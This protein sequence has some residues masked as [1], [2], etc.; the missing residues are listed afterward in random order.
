[1]GKYA[2]TALFSAVVT[3]VAVS[4]FWIWFYN[5]VLQG[6]P[7]VERSGNVVAVV[8]PRAPP[9][10]VA[11]QV[12]VG[13]SGLALP[14]MGVKSDQLTD[15]FTQARAN[16][17]LHDAIDIMAPEGT[18]VIAAADGTIEK[19]FF[20]HGGGGITIYERSPDQKWQYYYA[21]LSGLCAG[22][23]RGSAGE[24][25]PGHRSGW[26]YRRCERGRAASSFRHQHHGA[27]RAL[28]ERRR[29]STPIRCLPGK[30]RTGRGSAF[31]HHPFGL[32]LSK[33]CP[34]PR[35]KQPF[36]KLRAN[37]C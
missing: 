7:A 11:E 3:A 1:M 2:A 32:S 10:A 36:D 26:T 6:Q 28:V 4:A 20:S 37:G 18:P 34:P 35:E 8:P 15:T 22:P 25:R 17:R 16:G 14:V 21:H 5:T 33:P 29:P 19:L 24:A 27:G 9:V 12:V 13:P 23:R 30:R 31:S